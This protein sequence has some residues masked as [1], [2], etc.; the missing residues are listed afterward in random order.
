MAAVAAEAIEAPTIVLLLDNGQP[1]GE[2]QAAPPSG[3][4]LTVRQMGGKEDS[5]RARLS[6]AGVGASGRARREAEIQR[7]AK[8]GVACWRM[9]GQG[10]VYRT[11]CL[12]D[13]VCGFFGGEVKLVSCLGGVP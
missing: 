6:S 3:C 11:W 2:A 10:T 1:H 7:S 4:L 9:F 5:R 12:V 8:Q 13:E